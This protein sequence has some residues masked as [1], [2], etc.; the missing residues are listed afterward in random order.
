MIIEGSRIGAEVEAVLGEAGAPAVVA[1]SEPAMLLAQAGNSTQA[2]E[3]QPA[4]T[5]GQTAVI[6]LEVT[7]DQNNVVKLPD[8]TAIDEL[9]VAGPNLVF[10]QPDGSEIVVLNAALRIPTFV[11]GDVEIAQEVLIAALDTIGVDVAAGPDGSFS[12]VGSGPQSSGADFQQTQQGGQSEIEGFIDLLGDTDLGGDQ[13][14]GDEDL[15]DEGNNAPVI[16]SG[17]QVGAVV[18]SVD[19]P[20]GIDA[21]PVSAAG[22]IVFSEF[23]LGNAFTATITAREMVGSSLFNGSSPTS[24]QIADF[25]A[26]LTLGSL[27]PPA[28]G[29]NGSVPWTYSLG[30]NAVDF[31]S[32]GETVTL[33]FEVTI[34]DGIASATTTVTITVTGT[35]DAPVIAAVAQTDLVEPTDLSALGARIAVSFSDVDLSDIGHTAMIN[36]VTAQGQVQGLALTSGQLI[37]FVTPETV[38]KA[39]GSTAGTVELTFS[40]PSSA[41]DYLAAGERL[42]LTYTLAIDDGDGGVTERNF[43]VTVTGSNDGPAITPISPTGAVSDIA[44]TENPSADAGLQSATGSIS[45][46]DV[47]LSDRPTASF[48]PTSVVPGQ[49]LILTEGQQAALSGA[50]SIAPAAGNTNNGTI[51]WT[52]SIGEGALDF[53]AAGETVTLTYTI[54]VDDGKGGKASTDV[55]ITVTG[56]ND[57]P[58]IMPGDVT[59]SVSDVAEAVNPAADAG[60]QSTSGSIGFADVDLSDRPAASFAFSSITP[61]QGLTLTE[62]QET[63]LKAGFSITPAAGNTNNGTVGWSYA[64]AESALDFLA[65][66][67]R[68]TLTYT[69]TV[70]DGKGGKAST[71][72]TVTITGANDAPVLSASTGQITEFADRTLSFSAN[73][74]SGTMSFVDVDLNDT[75]HTAQV[76]SV[77]RGGETD[78]LLPPIFGDAYARS[79]F[80]LDGVSKAAGSSSGQVNW[81]FSAPDTTFDYLAQGQTATLTYRVRLRDGD[82]GESFQ[83]VTITIVGTN[84]RPVFLADAGRS[85]NEDRDQTGSDALERL[86]GRL[87]FVDF[88]RDDVGHAAS[89]TGLS[90]NGVTAGLDQVALRNALSITSV[91]KGIDDIGG[92]VRWSFGAADKLFDY[93]AAGERVTLT[94]EVTLND[95]EGASNSTDKTT[96]TI[97]ITGTNDRPTISVG[98][99]DSASASL[100]ESNATLHTS[101]TLAFTDVDLTDGHTVSAK[102]TSSVWSGGN[103]P[104]STLTAAQTALSAAIADAATGDG[105]GKIGW[106]FNLAAQHADFLTAGETLTLTY[107]V[108]LKDDSGS[109]N[110][111][112]TKTVTVTITGA[113]DAPVLTASTGQITEF[114]DR[115]LSFSANTVSG[116]MSFV[117]VDLNDTGHTAQVVSVTRGAETDGL[118]PPIFG[119]AYARSL[120]SLDGVSKA[121]GSSSGQVNWSFSA[122]DTTFDYLAQGQTATLT[123]RVR[124]RDGDGGESFQNVTIAIVGTNDRPVFLGDADRSGWE[125]IGQTGSN[126][127]ETFSGLLLF[128]DADRDDVGHTASVTGLS[129]SGVTMGLDQAAL[130]NALSI[131]SVTKTANSVL[132]SVAWSFA[133][134]DKLFDYL[135][136]GERVTLTYEVTLNDGEGASNSTDK[137]TVTITITGTND[138]PTISVGSGDS[139]SASLTEGNSGLQ[140]TGTLTVTDVDLSDTVHAQVVGVSGGGAGYNPAAALGFLTVSSNPASGGKLIW[141]FDSGSETFD[142]LPQGW[143]TKLDYMIRVSDGHGGFDEQ[144]VS[145]LITGTN[146]AP[147]ISVGAGDSTTAN[148]TESDAALQAAGTLS[149]M[150]AD[151]G[152]ALTAQV[153]GVSGGGAG[154]D[155]AA[156]LGFLTV[157]P[158]PA[159]GKL[160]WSF[161]SG[162]ETFD[163]L[164]QGWQTKLDYT[165]RVADGQGGFDDQVVSILITG[166]ND[167]PVISIGAGDSA[168]ANLTESNAALQAAGTLSVTDVDLGAALTAQVVGVSGGGAGYNPA[169]ALGFLTVSPNPAGGKLTWSFDSGFETFDFLPQGWQ[170][171][172]DYTIR[173][174]DGQ[175]G[176]DEQVVSITI[177]GTNDAPVISVGDGDSAGANLTESDASLQASGTLT[178]TDVDLGSVIEARVLSV[179]GTGL[180]YNPA[181]APAFLTVSPNPTA[182]G[183]LTWS[184]NSGSETFD[185]LSQGSTTTIDY[186]I[187]VYDGHGG[188]G[189]QVVSITLTGTND[190]PV[191]SIVDGDSISA[192]LAET[193]TGLQATGLLTATDVD[194]GSVIEARV[195]SVTGMTPGYDTQA[196]RDFLSVSPKAAPDG[197]LTWSFDSGSE[198]FNF[199]R[200]GTTATFDYT[201][202]VYDGHG[203]YD[204]QVVSIK[205]IGTNDAPVITGVA[206]PGPVFES[207]GNSSAQDILATGGKLT[208]FDADRGDTLTPS[209]AGKATIAW[210]GGALPAGVDVAALIDKSA[211]VF[212]ASQTSNGGAVTFDWS[213]D[214]KAANLNW[215]GEGETLT[216]TYLAHVDDGYGVVGS[217]PIT[218]TI[219]GTNDAPVARNDT[220]VVSN[221]SSP[222]ADSTPAIW[223]ASGNNNNRQ[224][225]QSID[226]SALKIATNP[227]LEDDDLPSATI[228]GSLSNGDPKDFYKIELKAGEKL[229]LDIDHTTGWLDTDLTLYDP[230]GRVVDYE[231]DGFLTYDPLLSYTARENGVYYIEVGRLDWSGSYDLQ[232]SIKNF[233]A[234]AQPYTFATSELLANDSDPDG[235]SLSVVSV[236]GQGVSLNGTTI[237]VQPGVTSFNYTI[238]DGKTQSTATVTLQP[239]ANGMTLSMAHDEMFEARGSDNLALGGDGDDFLVGGSGDDILV[240][241]LGENTLAGGEGADTFVIDP[242]ALTGGA[243]DFIADFNFDEGDQIDLT[244]LLEGIADSPADV[245]NMLSLDHAGGDTN[246]VFNDGHGDVAIATLDGN[247]AQVRILFGDQDDNP[248]SAVV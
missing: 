78:G 239:G 110:S 82:G 127:Q 91:S 129:A 15:G 116:T 236:S 223:E 19:V 207:S 224:N 96:V 248:T 219:H 29:S 214:P 169:A 170:T 124:L 126:A 36:G 16:V 66:G 165:I 7:P 68:V 149:V 172:L 134:A 220:F 242:A 201:I 179:S 196:A 22:A 118:L 8:G 243:K 213:Y 188:Y 225:A 108:T 211:I 69:I 76:V 40:A 59:G 175:G 161:D 5:G 166:T 200:Q 227:D 123:Y 89:V 222:I 174:S 83:N 136:A 97:T 60:L 101:E 167:A 155:P 232:V 41:F 162:S 3:E 202:R 55:T 131:G 247:V 63:A 94:Y 182:G 173:V 171:K 163:F 119:D 84:D 153:V 234:P 144:V 125:N 74:V 212:S 6:R 48:A 75:G 194:L 111:T 189:D 245:G 72:V 241:G 49:G 226:R 30:N 35:N 143:Q 195:L 109:A 217:Q 135:A 92:T 203:G 54:T 4:A 42:T 147:V 152:A 38:A 11:I 79:L 137:T 154:Y 215:L 122:P 17:L 114:A 2:G 181:T 107:T 197:K 26:G 141:S 31:L 244:S 10:V 159:G 185:F 90:A 157:S 112:A 53:L 228:K 47:D 1:E 70:D 33:G 9:R 57:G 73:T 193:N 14:G 50:F 121:A 45:F 27:T 210:S 115:T 140:T 93:L 156:A 120:F 106:T 21:D 187:R 88:D 52:Y 209:I 206:N 32:A 183:K 246:L 229:I 67:E 145:I 190:A 204:D 13:A 205:I 18:E 238:S 237:T 184:F 25:L 23:D 148:L 231:D 130:A 98:A 62:D 44:E 103:V 164:P 39:A 150:D 230:S 176:F 199:L 58:V 71:D 80:S 104:A 87:D 105:S 56:A 235:D 81:S 151:L 158:N 37:A 240:A 132:G 133:A 142:F 28:V 24:A 216:V 95:G 128:G 46:A 138:R 43:V 146:D 77:M 86:S 139:A 64:I 192:S 233:Q 65:A 12:V 168:S 160:I 117:D 34:G 99:G 198:A 221:P 102:L 113:N 180:G 100:T 51:G 218:V 186:T 85:G 208:V 178:A 61:G 20:D 177:T 191:I